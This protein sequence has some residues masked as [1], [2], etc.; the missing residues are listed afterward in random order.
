MEFDKLKANLDECDEWYEVIG[1][2]SRKMTQFLSEKTQSPVYDSHVFTDVKATISGR[3]E[4][5]HP[6]PSKYQ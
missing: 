4:I 3:I 5:I 2:I 1:W 6:N